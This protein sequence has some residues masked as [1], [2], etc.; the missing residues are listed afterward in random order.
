MS[1]GVLNSF[2]LTR[3][4]KNLFTVGFILS[5]LL[6]QSFIVIRSVNL[7]LSE[8]SVSQPCSQV[9]YKHFQPHKK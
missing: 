1:D 4:Y 8:G 3:F 5:K 7:R 2:I 9:L 6:I